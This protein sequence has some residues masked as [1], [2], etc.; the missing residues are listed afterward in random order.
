MDKRI[1][2]ARVS[3]E[4]LSVLSERDLR[5]AIDQIMLR[6]AAICGC[7]L[8]TTEFFAEIIAEELIVF[9]QDFGFSHLTLAEVLLALRMNANG[10]VKYSAFQIEPI[11][12]T[13]HC[14]NVD[15]VSKVLSNY[16]TL[17][18]YFERKI[19]NHIDGY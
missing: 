1:I 5:A 3:N 14:F 18:S 2:D 6:G 16:L 8:P 7:P 13:G 15:Y 12:F 4:S 9:I 10:G 11:F 19:Q 17:R